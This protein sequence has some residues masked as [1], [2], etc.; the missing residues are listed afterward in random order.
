MISLLHQTIFKL[1]NQGF[2]VQNVNSVDSTPTIELQTSPSPKMISY[3][4]SLVLKPFLEE[5]EAVLEE[6]S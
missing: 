2:L 3:G 4:R 1:I 5:S 6:L